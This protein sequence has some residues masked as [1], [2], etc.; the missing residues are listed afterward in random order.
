MKLIPVTVLSGSSG[1]GKTTL[2]RRLAAAREGQKVAVLTSALDGGDRDGG[3]CESNTKDGGIRC[4]C[5]EHLGLELRKIGRAKEWDHV[6][7]ESTAASEPLPVA[8]SFALDDGR[9]TPVSRYLKVDALITLVDATR[10]LDDLASTDTLASRGLTVSPKD[11]RRVVEA[12]V[13]QIE[14]ADVILITKA[15]L[16]DSARVAS[17]AALLR[18]LNPGARVLHGHAAEVPLADLMDTG[19]FEYDKAVAALHPARFFEGPEDAADHGFL[20]FG[21]RRRR[22]FHPERFEAMVH[23]SF[24]GVVRSKGIFW[25][26][27]SPDAAGE[28]S[29]AGKVLH[30]ALGGSFWAA[31]P[32]SEWPVSDKR[33]AE[34]K[35]LFEGPYGDRRQELAFVIDGIDRAALERRLDACLLTD[36]ELALGPAGWRTLGGTTTPEA[37]EHEAHGHGHAHSTHSHSDGDGHAPHEHAHGHERFK[38]HTPEGGHHSN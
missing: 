32:E 38:G 36:E 37:H 31:T 11:Q 21:Y 29:Q 24:E 6:L 16:A 35:A 30:H 3:L 18:K 26:A 19:L 15:D 27:S 17:L 7:V 4:E 5:R 22:P 33:K 12:L 14:L 13:A 8:E 1:A 28:W 34:I 9:G 2:L 20:R 25:F 10:F 23:G